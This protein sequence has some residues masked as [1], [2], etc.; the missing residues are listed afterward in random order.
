MFG[1]IRPAKERLSAHDEKLFQA[2]YCGLCHELG[3]KYGFAARFALNFDFT[4]LA[5]LLS[6]GGAGEEREGRCL[7][8]PVKARPYLAPT[9]A[10]E[11]AADES[12]ILAYWQL[13]DGIADSRGPKRGKY[14]L[15]ASALRGGYERAAAARPGFDA[16]VRQ[17]L[18]ELSAL[19]AERCPSLAS[20]FP[21]QA[22][23]GSAAVRVLYRPPQK[24]P[25]TEWFGDVVDGTGL[26]PVTSCTSSRCS[27]S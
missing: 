2:V 24:N 1:Y 4:F 23:V 7:P 6:G 10:M 3:R 27:T 16:A 22:A 5:I 15:A 19:E 21:P 11:L 12:V 14:R 25:Q 17:R 26:E 13:K 8:H 18:G 20:L 9:P